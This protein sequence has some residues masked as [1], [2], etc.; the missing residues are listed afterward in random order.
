M[1]FGIGPA[2]AWTFGGVIALL[3]VVAV[4]ACWNPASRAVRVDPITALREE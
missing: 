3:G 1:L 4:V 2:D